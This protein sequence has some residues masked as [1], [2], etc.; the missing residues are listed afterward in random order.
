MV[1]MGLDVAQGGAMEYLSGWMNESIVWSKALFLYCLLLQY[2]IIRYYNWREGHA[3]LL[4]SCC[5]VD[6][7]LYWVVLIHY[8][9][10]RTVT[11]LHTG[12]TFICHT[13]NFTFSHQPPD[14][15]LLRNYF[16]PERN[17]KCD[18]KITPW[19]WSFLS[20]YL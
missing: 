16:S 11:V 12:H 18:L 17:R 8:C 3:E 19:E 6:N 4:L 13:D 1:P 20:F 15:S 2:N 10:V 14:S 7:E 5:L 9:L